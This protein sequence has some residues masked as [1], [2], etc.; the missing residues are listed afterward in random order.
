M[1]IPE[2]NEGITGKEFQAVFGRLVQLCGSKRSAA[3]EVGIRPQSLLGWEYRKRIP[4]DQIDNVRAVI[5]RKAEE[6]GT[7]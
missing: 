6:L 1:T 5:K 2:N 3:K 7:V 4:G